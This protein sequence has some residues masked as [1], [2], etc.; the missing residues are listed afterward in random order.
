M[1]SL[2]HSVC[3]EDGEFDIMRSKVAEWLCMQP[4]VRQY[5][6]D[7]AKETGV[8]KYDDAIGE[9]HGVDYDY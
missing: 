3:G 2:P 7:A 4:E 6:F 5:V 9:W 8:I 1:P